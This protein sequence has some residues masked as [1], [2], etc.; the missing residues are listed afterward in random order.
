VVAAKPRDIDELSLRLPDGL[1]LRYASIDELQLL[2]K[3]ARMMS[4]ATFGA[5]V[6]NLKHDGR[7]ESV[8]LCRLLP[9]GKLRVIS[10]NHR[11][12]AAKQA[13]I[14]RLAVL[15][16]T[17]DMTRGEEVAKQLSHNAIVG[18][19][20]SVILRELFNEI[21]DVVLKEYSG[22]DDGIL[23]Q[24]ASIEPQALTDIPL[25]YHV[26]SFAFLPEEVERLL[27][28]LDKVQADI[29]TPTILARWAEHDRLLNALA[30]K[31]AERDV[32]NGAT[33][34]M[35]LL[36]MVE[37]SMSVGSET[38]DTSAIQ[39]EEGGATPTPALQTKGTIP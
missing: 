28:M 19:D 5:L 36:D 3:N 29:K 24:L 8:P 23:L 6:D 16:I 15:V 35:L 13:G 39:A 32:R 30:E 1:T 2:E 37:E 14:Q 9:D 21:D 18:E 26:I 20:D 11:V 33:A 34:M 17:D 7:V 38:S 25:D 22:L 10:G 31:M 4:A 12:M 27:S